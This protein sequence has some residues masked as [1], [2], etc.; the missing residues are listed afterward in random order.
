M[1]EVAPS[2]PEVDITVRVHT[3][4]VLMNRKCEIRHLLV[5]SFYNK[6]VHVKIYLQVFVTTLH[7][8]NENI[9]LHYK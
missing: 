1:P 4:F 6:M 9:L 3:Q 5:L 2:F 7:I 8:L